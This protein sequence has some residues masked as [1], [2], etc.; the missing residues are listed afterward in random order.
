MILM[1]LYSIFRGLLVARHAADRSLEAV[2]CDPLSAGPRAVL[3]PAERTALG[4]LEAYLRRTEGRE[5]KV[6]TDDNPEEVGVG[7]GS[8]FIPSS[9]QYK[10][11]DRQ[12]DTPN[13]TTP[14]CAL[15]QII[16]T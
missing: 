15:T 2:V 3:G 10:P 4:K 5:Y 7:F 16:N 14:T 1:F 6:L 9:Q 11:T 8:L 12:T 13:E